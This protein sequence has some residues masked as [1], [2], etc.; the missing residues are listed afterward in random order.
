MSIRVAPIL[1]LSGRAV[2]SPWLFA[3]VAAFA[4][5]T[6]ILHDVA[7]VA[8]RSGEVS[9]RVEAAKA[10]LLADSAVVAALG[11]GDL[12][13]ARELL[14]GVEVRHD[15]SQVQVRVRLPGGNHAFAGMMLSGRAPAA[16]AEAGSIGEGA[17]TLDGF[18]P[19]WPDAA[20]RLDPE[21][22]ARAAA[23]PATST[24]QR[25]A[26]IALLRWRAG[27]DSDDFVLSVSRGVA[28]LTAAGELLVVPGHLWLV[29]GDA[30]LVVALAHD[31]VVVVQG[32]LYLH[33]S[34]EV[35]GPGRLVLVAA[36]P[37]GA[38]RFAD[39]DGNGRWSEAD[40]LLGA[41]VFTGPIE[42]AGS[43][44]CGSVDGL[45]SITMAASLVVS[46]QLH[47]SA[48]LRVDGP[49]IVEHGVTR[50]R[51]TAQLVAAGEW[52]FEPERERVAGF[53]TSG[54][55]RPSFLRPCAWSGRESTMMQQPLYVAAPAR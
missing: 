55:P 20:P 30:P 3:V 38:V 19:L 24:L 23:A 43:V 45:A 10:E 2:L 53:V 54:L 11:G 4:V 18:Q 34:L 5:V 28:D 32:N 47:L 44:Y 25:D 35:R 36:C 15:D 17:A 22:L 42:G 52:R 33:R 37:A 48:G 7:R 40:R 14:S 6:W 9:R 27:T 39:E 26:G 51:A 1:W 50:L 16:F 29:A 41:S 49:L 31:L 13:E 8:R 46:G 12:V 21:A